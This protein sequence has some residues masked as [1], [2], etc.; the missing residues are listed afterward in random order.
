M[1]IGD[2]QEGSLNEVDSPETWPTHHPPPVL[3]FPSFPFPVATGRDH[4]D[5]W[6][7]VN[8]NLTHGDRALPKQE[9]WLFNHFLTRANSALSCSVI[10][11]SNHTPLS[12]SLETH[13]LCVAKPRRHRGEDGSV[14]IYKWDGEEHSRRWPQG[15]E[16]GK[17]DAE[18]S[19]CLLLRGSRGQ[20][21]QIGDCL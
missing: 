4:S 3:L 13:P 15:M 18:D 10:T 16:V 9:E 11:S 2:F 20:G 1:V 21:G 12:R 6:W 17:C 19:P 5:G 14:W 8:P 7:G